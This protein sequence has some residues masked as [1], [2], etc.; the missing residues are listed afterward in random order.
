MDLIPH[1]LYHRLPFGRKVNLLGLASFYFRR[2]TFLF[3]GFFF[4]S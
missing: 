4:R 1:P 3:G 2:I